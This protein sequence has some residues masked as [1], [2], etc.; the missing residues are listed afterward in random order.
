VVVCLEQGAKSLHMF[1]LMPLHPETPLSLA[2]FKS[3]LFL[4]FWYRLIQVV[5]EKKPL[6]GCSSS[7]SGGSG[8]GYLPTQ[9]NAGVVW[10]MQRIAERDVD[11]GRGRRRR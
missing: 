4:P 2:E 8:G 1:Q 3:G 5:L 7:S 11:V 10:A 9:F 6:N